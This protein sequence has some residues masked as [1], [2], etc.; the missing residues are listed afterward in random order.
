MITEAAYLSVIQGKEKAFEEDFK[1]ASKYISS[2]DGY[3]KHSLLKCIERES[4]YL[5]IV[6]WKSLEDHTIGFRKSKEYLEWKKLLHH[7]YDPFPSVEHF[8]TIITNNKKAD[9][10]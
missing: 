2:I 6:E 8:E 5:L 9:K 4:T 3:I 7:Y 10:D 1:K